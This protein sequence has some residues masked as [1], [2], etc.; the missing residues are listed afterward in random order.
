MSF[1]H[2][3]PRVLRISIKASFSKKCPNV[4]IAKALLLQSPDELAAMDHWHTASF[5]IHGLTFR[6]WPPCS[7]DRSKSL[8][9]PLNFLH[10][11]LGA[12]MKSCDT[13]PSTTL[14]STANSAHAGAHWHDG[15]LREQDR[16]P[17]GIRTPTLWRELPARGVPRDL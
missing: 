14:Q 1:M 4:M 16:V 15:L 7:A 17:P 12:V 11:R 9:A 10:V 3:C 6:N 2:R 5:S 13:L 8:V